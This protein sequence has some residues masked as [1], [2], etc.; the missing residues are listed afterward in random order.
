MGIKKYDNNRRYNEIDNVVKY[1]NLSIEE[2]K[3]DHEKYERLKY[4]ISNKINYI[5]L[6]DL[7]YLDNLQDD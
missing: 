3:E 6:C 2:L 1:F 7:D 4:T 5:Q